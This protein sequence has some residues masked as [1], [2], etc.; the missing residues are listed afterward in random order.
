M[1]IVERALGIRRNVDIGPKKP[2]WALLLLIPAPSIGVLANGVLAESDIAV[3]A[4]IGLVIWMICKVWIVAFPAFWHRRLD[5]G[6]FGFSS[7]AEGSGL[8]PWLE[9]ILLG[10]AL[11]AILFVTFLAARPHINLV[12]IGVSIRAVG[13]DSWPKVIAAILFWVFINSV[14]EE[15]VYR[16]FITNQA[17][18][19]IGDYPIRVGAISVAAF[20]LHH[21]VA[22]ALVAP[23]WWIALLAAGAV[24]VGGAAFS[25]LYHR[26]SSIWPAWACHA[27]LDVVVFGGVAWIALVAT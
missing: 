21:F 2:I 4:L 11:S 9:G 27:I 26:H 23:S 19:I 20:T 5:Q 18:S 6:E 12:D 24:A 1:R 14:V 16:W 17:A 3:Y 10:G 25:F 15:Y 13:L 8:R 7:L 22:V